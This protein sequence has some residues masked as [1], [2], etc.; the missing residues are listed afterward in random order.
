P[1]PGR[2]PSEAV[3][4]SRRPPP[5]G[6]R[7]ADRASRPLSPGHSG[8]GVRRRPAQLDVRLANRHGDRL[9]AFDLQQPVRDRLRHG[10][11]QPVSLAGHGLT[12]PRIQIAVVERVPDLV[13]V[14]GAVQV[15]LHR[16]IDEEHLAG[17]LL[18]R[19]QSMVGVEGHLAEHDPIGHGDGTP[20]AAGGHPRTIASVIRAT[21]TMAP[22]SCTRTKSAPC[23]IATATVAAVPSSRSSTG[24]FNTLPMLPLREVPTK[25]GRP[26]AVSSRRRRRTSIFCG[27]VS[28]NPYPGSMMIRASGIPAAT[29]AAIRSRRNA[30]VAARTSGAS[31]RSFQSITTTGTPARA[32]SG[33]IP[34]SRRPDTSFTIAAPASRAAA[35]T[36]AEIV[37]T[38]TGTP[39]AA[40]RRTA[41][42]VRRASSAS[43]TGTA[44]GR[45]DRPPTSRMSAPAAL[46]VRPS[47]SAAPASPARPSPANE[48]GAVLMIPTTYVRAPN[49]RW[50]GPHQMGGGVIEAPPGP[51]F[52]PGG[53]RGGEARRR[54]RAEAPPGGRT[55]R[56]RRPPRR[57]RGGALP[58]RPVRR[59]RAGTCGESR[60]GASRRARDC[61]SARAARLRDTPYDQ[62]PT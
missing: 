24:R 25:T 59:P 18:I 3:D 23:A 44:P 9:D 60:G 61:A 20:P 52:A 42:T 10:L 14:A 30:A 58:L 22:T 5:I 62:R 4:G 8:R 46:I 33:A 54:D 12:D 39:P 2:S 7:Q 47:A 45:V 32:T 57:G 29:A 38:L 21:R 49:S 55:P 50:S 53:G 35:A 19:I 17:G 1:T 26:S 6:C 56:A 13:G 16:D 48:S 31:E 15:G 40:R 27:T 51:G 36:L 11:Q 37:S 28:P 41:G 34:G 43:S